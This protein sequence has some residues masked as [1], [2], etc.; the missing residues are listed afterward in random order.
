M[1]PQQR[2]HE[3]RPLIHTFDG[4][5]APFPLSEYRAQYTRSRTTQSSKPAIWMN[6][7]EINRDNNS[8]CPHD[9]RRLSMVASGSGTDGGDGGVVCGTKDRLHGYDQVLSVVVALYALQQRRREEDTAPSVIVAEK[10][11]AADDKGSSFGAVLLTSAK[12]VTATAGAGAATAVT[13]DVPVCVDGWEGEASALVVKL[14]A[15][16]DAYPSEVRVFV[17]VA[18]VVLYQNALL[19]TVPPWLTAPIAEVTRSIFPS[20]AKKMFGGYSH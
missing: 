19:Y 16:R 9:G 3:I 13:E 4:L 10:G 15:L 1:Y 14:R 2:T 20:C 17:V 12:G 11:T 7:S 6:V 8:A 5:L 18:I